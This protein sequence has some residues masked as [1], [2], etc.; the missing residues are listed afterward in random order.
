MASEPIQH[1][2]PGVVADCARHLAMIAGDLRAA[3][4]VPL[5]RLDDDGVAPEPLTL[6]DEIW[7]IAVRLGWPIGARIDGKEVPD[8]RL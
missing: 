4:D 6:A 7:L 3:G 2:E 8:D 1:I 5:V